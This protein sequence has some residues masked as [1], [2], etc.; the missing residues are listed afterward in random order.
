M[1]VGDLY[2]DWSL[3]VA[4]E[5]VASSILDIDRLQRFKQGDFD[6]RMCGISLLLEGERQCVI[7]KNASFTA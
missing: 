7:S 4:S 6:F 1:A 2:A 3:F 5:L